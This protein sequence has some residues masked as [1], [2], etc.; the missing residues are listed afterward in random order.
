MKLKATPPKPVVNDHD[1]R[2]A[3]IISGA[4]A[5]SPVPSAPPP[6]VRQVVSAP[7]KAPHV[8][9]DLL[10]QVNVRLPEPLALKLKHVSNMTDQQKQ[11]LVA[12]ALGPLLDKKLRE[13][14]YGKEDL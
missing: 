4:T 10:V 8:R 7:W 9:Q 3:A 2:I 13:L 11:D 6:A 5:A 14:G 12:E 1:E